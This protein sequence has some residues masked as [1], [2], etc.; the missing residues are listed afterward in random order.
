MSDVGMTTINLFYK[1]EK[2][3]FSI[4]TSSQWKSHVFHVVV[5]LICTTLNDEL[6]IIFQSRDLMGSLHTDGLSLCHLRISIPRQ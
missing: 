1:D 3:D 2:H 6:L 5:L 4:T